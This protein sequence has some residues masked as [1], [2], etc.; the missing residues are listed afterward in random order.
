MTANRAFIT[1]SLRLKMHVLTVFLYRRQ[2]KIIN[3]WF[4][5]GSGEK[6]PPSNQRSGGFPNWSH[7]G[8]SGKPQPDNREAEEGTGQESCVGILN[9]FYGD[10]IKWHDV[11]CHHQKPWV[12]E[13]S[14]ELL[15]YARSTSRRRIP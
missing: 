10:G 15:A 13:D 6:M 4:W 12:C 8:G 7:T 1:A 11:A 9:N 14:D 3:G 5:S 2:P